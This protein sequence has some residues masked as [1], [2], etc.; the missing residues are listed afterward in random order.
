MIKQNPFEWASAAVRTIAESAEEHVR[1][2]NNAVEDSCH[3]V[4]HWVDSA[5]AC[6]LLHSRKRLRSNTWTNRQTNRS[7]SRID[8]L[9]AFYARRSR[10]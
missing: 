9:H 3:L 5:F 10:F 1:I 4:M 2:H 8:T 6:G 7:H